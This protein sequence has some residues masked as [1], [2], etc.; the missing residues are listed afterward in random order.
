MISSVSQPRKTYSVY[1]LSDPRTSEVRYIGM[2]HNV[3]QRYTQ[4]IYL[5]DKSN[6]VKQT[7]IDDM[8][9]HHLYPILTI[10]EEGLE[11]SIALVREK[12][13]LQVYLEQGANITNLRDAELMPWELR[14]DK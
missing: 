13:W 1:A 14:E 5:R 9:T 2:T 8:K 10:I 11:K 4:H 12:Y 3:D 7:W 6:Q